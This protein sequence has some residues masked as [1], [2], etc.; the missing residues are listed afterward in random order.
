[1]TEIPVENCH[2]AVSGFESRV[3]SL[4][5][6]D[7]KLPSITSKIVDSVVSLYNHKEKEKIHGERH[8]KM[9]PSPATPFHNFD[10]SQCLLNPL[11]K[12]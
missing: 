11:Y 2:E 9:L 1:M 7:R 5:G 4:I 10:I 8:L 12:F 3:Q 6:L